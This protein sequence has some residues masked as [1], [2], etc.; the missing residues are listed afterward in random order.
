MSELFNAG[1]EEDQAFINKVT[2]LYLL[3]LHIWCF[4]GALR[5]EK[6]ELSAQVKKLQ[7]TVDHLQGSLNQAHEEVM[8]YSH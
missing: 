4:S 6:L 8:F 1:K 2:C 7:A 3:L 5:Q